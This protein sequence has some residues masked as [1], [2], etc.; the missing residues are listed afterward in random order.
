M[1]KKNNHQIFKIV[2]LLSLGLIALYFIMSEHSKENVACLESD[3]IRVEIGGERFAFPRKKGIK[4]R[5][6]GEAL[7]H[8]L[9]G[10]DVINIRGEGYHGSASSSKACQKSEDA[11]WKIK[12]LNLDV[13]PIACSDSI[14]CTK[15][16][17][18]PDIKNISDTNGFLETQHPTNKEQLLERCR[19]PEDEN[20]IWH[21]CTYIFKDR[22]TYFFIKFD[23]EVYP[24]EQIE[25][26]KDILLETIRKH[27]IQ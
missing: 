23:G 11:V 10:D 18:H 1:R 4:Y 17:I 5:K 24:P 25:Q 9:A 3:T 15:K 8:S 16:T 2:S 22:N 21:H 12:H 19:R 6:G 13:I 20:Q 26:T 7:V 14:D 27:R